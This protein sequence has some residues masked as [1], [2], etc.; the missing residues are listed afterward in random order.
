MGLTNCLTTYIN[1]KVYAILERDEEYEVAISK[2]FSNRKKAR[3][4]VFEKYYANCDASDAKVIKHIDYWID[5]VN[6]E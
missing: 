3:K 4:H 1:M 5:V 2:I 6:V